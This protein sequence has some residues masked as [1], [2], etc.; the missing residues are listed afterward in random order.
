MS[1]SGLVRGYLCKQELTDEL[2]QTVAGSLETR[3]RAD[4]ERCKVTLQK[5]ENFYEV[6]VYHLQHAYAVAL[7]INKAATLKEE[8]PYAVDQYLLGQLEKVGLRVR[9]E[10]RV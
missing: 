2:V 10:A 6:V 3:F 9:K 8:G 4:D 5:L 1:L 7:D